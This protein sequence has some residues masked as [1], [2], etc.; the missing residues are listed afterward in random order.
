[1]T[2]MDQ[3]QFAPNSP[4]YHAAADRFVKLNALLQMT[5][6]YIDAKERASRLLW[7]IPVSEGDA[8]RADRQDHLPQEITIRRL[9]V[10]P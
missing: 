7:S 5:G 2:P 6:A 10:H 8:P 9:I 4:K 3:E 1:M